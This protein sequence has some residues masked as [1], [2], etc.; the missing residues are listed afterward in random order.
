[1]ALLGQRIS[2]YQVHP[3]AGERSGPITQAACNSPHHTQIFNTKDKIYMTCE[4]LF[5]HN[6]D[7]N[8]DT[9]Y[10]MMNIEDVMLSETSW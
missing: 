3:I 2:R 7:G 8:S 9:H 4:I 1:M 10:S 6:L 5:S